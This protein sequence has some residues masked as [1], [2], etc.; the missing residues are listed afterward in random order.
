M[1]DFWTNILRYP[2][3]FISSLAGLVLVILTPFR[4]LFKNPTSRIFLI[5]FIV[6]FLVSLFLILKTMVGL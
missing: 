5:I 6:L 4:N 1:N 2:R 3:F